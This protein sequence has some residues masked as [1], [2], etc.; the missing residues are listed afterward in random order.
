[1]MKRLLATL[2][3]GATLSTGAL[4]AGPAAT[5]GAVECPGGHWPAYTAGRP[6]EVAVGMTGMALWRN[7]T[8]WH[9]R[10][11][12]EGRDLAVFRGSV[13][14]DGVISA[15]SAQ[16]EK[17][18]WV[19]RRNKSSFGYLFTNF[20]GVDGLDFRTACASQ[21]TVSGKLNGVS[22]DPTTVYIGAD[23]THPE[24][25][26]VTIEKEIDAA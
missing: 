1:M 11:S 17:G 26:P 13:S 3:T 18:D 23:N 7:D 21:I 10:V 8:G 22:I 6:T 14:T 9:L 5:A 16:T 12:E 4:L 15:V 20:G 25:F 24:S 2:V 19:V